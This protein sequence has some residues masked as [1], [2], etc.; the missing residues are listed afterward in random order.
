M[1]RHSTKIKNKI[2]VQYNHHKTSHIGQST[3]FFSS[4]DSAHIV[5]GGQAS[6]MRCVTSQSFYCWRRPLLCNST[7]W[8]FC[9]NNIVWNEEVGEMSS[10]WH[11][12]DEQHATWT[13]DIKK[14]GTLARHQRL[15]IW[16]PVDQWARVTS[17]PPTSR[18]STE[19]CCIPP[20]LLL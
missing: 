6:P 12:L 4:I 15:E 19:Q 3:V 17:T 9:Y 2:K 8:V 7:G 16:E 5:G 18:W 11:L 10:V 1:D 13:H 20:D 14:K